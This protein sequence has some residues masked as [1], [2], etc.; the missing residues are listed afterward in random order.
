MTVRPVVITGDPVLHRPAAKVTDFNDDL[1]TLIADMHETMDAANGVGLA[2]PQIG[3]GLRIFT[4]VFGNDDDAPD[5]G[6]I[7][8]PVL[9][10]GKI[11]EENP[12]PDEEAEGC[13]SVPGLSYPLKR[14][15]WVKIAGFDPHGV[16]IGWEATG[17][18]ARVMQHE[19]DHLDGKLYVDRLNT[20]WARKAKKAIRAEGWPKAGGTWQP[21][22]DQDPFGH[23]E[24]A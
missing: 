4:F 24:E 17:W 6:E 21:G 3:V 7:V 16:P 19:Y 2:A 8:N 22:V 14:A 1:R 10:V 11:T 9:T 15:E 13:L 23:G 20:K 18:F 12:D 5:R